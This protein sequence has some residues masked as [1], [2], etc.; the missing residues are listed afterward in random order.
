MF[1]LI[2][3][4]IWTIIIVIV[5]WGWTKQKPLTAVLI[6]SLY[7]GFETYLYF[8]HRLPFLPIRFLLFNVASVCVFLLSSFVYSRITHMEWEDAVFQSTC[9][10]ICVIITVW[11]LLPTVFVFYDW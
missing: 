8:L 2:D 6:V 3:G 9:W 1:F 10:E 11:L 7:V 5:M 4:V